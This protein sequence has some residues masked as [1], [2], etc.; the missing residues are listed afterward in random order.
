MV[1]AN[2]PTNADR[3]MSHCREHGK[4]LS[5]IFL[6]GDLGGG[7][8]VFVVCFIVSLNTTYLDGQYVVATEGTERKK[9][10][11]SK[12]HNDYRICDY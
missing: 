12:Q 7:K 10:I 8:M 1:T 2:L 11:E 4:N 9:K 6:D 3:Q 5:T